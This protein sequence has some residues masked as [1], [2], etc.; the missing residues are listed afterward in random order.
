MPQSG[1][2]TVTGPTASSRVDGA[3]GGLRQSGVDVCGCAG[4]QRAPC[5]AQDGFEAE[6]E[7]F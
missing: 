7:E 6:Q 5:F 3:C 2:V 4:E 1:V